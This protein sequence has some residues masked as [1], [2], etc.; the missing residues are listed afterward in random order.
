MKSEFVCF[1]NNIPPYTIGFCCKTLSLTL[2]YSYIV[3]YAGPLRSLK[4]LKQE[5][6]IIKTDQECG[7]CFDHEV[8]AEPGDR[9]VCYNLIDSKK[10]LDWSPEFDL[11]VNWWWFNLS[12]TLFILLLTHTEV[13]RHLDSI[14]KLKGT[15]IM[16]KEQ[17]VCSFQNVSNSELLILRIYN[18]NYHHKF[19][20]KSYLHVNIVLTGKWL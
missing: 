18:N 5:V 7:I 2:Y 17:F 20:L 12:A 15:F 3:V 14:L 10:K 4:H 8:R 11:R 19:N 1:S 16:H 9:V 13:T 6:N